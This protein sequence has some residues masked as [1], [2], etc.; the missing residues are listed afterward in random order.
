MKKDDLP[1]LLYKTIAQMGGKGTLLEICKEFWKQYEDE[2]R[3]SGDLFYTWQYDIRWAAT[4]LRKIGRMAD[5]N[6][7]DKGVWEI[8]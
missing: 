5:T 7:C 8:I 6:C 4:T 3:K 1:I 2:L